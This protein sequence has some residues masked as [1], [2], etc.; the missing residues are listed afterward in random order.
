[1]PG[2]MMVSSSI[3]AGIKLVPMQASWSG[4]GKIYASTWLVL[5]QMP[6]RCQ[7]GASSSVKRH[8]CQYQAGITPEIRKVLL[9]GS[10]KVS[11]TVPGPGSMIRRQRYQPRDQD[12]G[13]LK[14][15]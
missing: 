12:H 6:G 10:G 14:D 15:P 2:S 1:M 13:T 5:G 4:S 7:A 9:M 8:H 3:S 11:G